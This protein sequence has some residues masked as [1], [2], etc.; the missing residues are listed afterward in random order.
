MNNKA[1]EIYRL[2]E[3]QFSREKEQTHLKAKVRF[4]LEEEE[5]LCYIEAPANS[6]EKEPLIG[7]SSPIP[8][9]DSLDFEM[10][11]AVMTKFAG[12]VLFRNQLT[13]RQMTSLIEGFKERTVSEILFEPFRLGVVLEVTNS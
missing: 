12:E 1:I 5:Y 13:R 7:I 4:R 8:E 9:I 3:F 6:G 10:F 11:Q 2:H